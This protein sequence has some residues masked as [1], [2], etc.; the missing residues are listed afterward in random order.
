MLLIQDF[1]SII[2]IDKSYKVDNY[3]VL[4]E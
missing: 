3:K 2:L 1:V 4:D